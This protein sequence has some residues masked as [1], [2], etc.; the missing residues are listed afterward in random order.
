MVKSVL[1]HKK[2]RNPLWLK[3]LRY[4]RGA[5]M[6]L[7]AMTKTQSPMDPQNFK[8]IFY[9][10]LTHLILPRSSDR[11]LDIKVQALL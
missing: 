5:G 1:K 8:F 2:Q 7:D 9:S 3:M 6:S 10:L 4:W 11:W